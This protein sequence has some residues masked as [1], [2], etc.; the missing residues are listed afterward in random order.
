MK[1]LITVMTLPQ[2]YRALVDARS[3]RTH[4]TAIIQAGGGSQ[5]NGFR[6][7][8][9]SALTPDS[10]IYQQVA[11]AIEPALSGQAQ[12]NT[13]GATHYYAPRGMPNA[14]SSTPPARRTS[15]AS[16]PTYAPRRRRAPCGSSSAP[17]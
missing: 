6:T 16:S 1:K 11:A 12:D 9:Y 4:S 2:M 8:L 14:S 10:P 15:P 13:G 17:R 7:P 5:Y 3:R